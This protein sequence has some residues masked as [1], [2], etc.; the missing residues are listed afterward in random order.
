MGEMAGETEEGVTLISQWKRK[1]LTLKHAQTQ[2]H[3]E[4]CTSGPSSF[5]FVSQKK[6]MLEVNLLIS[7]IQKIT[8]CSR[9]LISYS[10]TAVGCQL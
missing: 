9:W 4:A 5:Y 10:V 2:T 1:K 7:S 8:Y 6:S 3:R